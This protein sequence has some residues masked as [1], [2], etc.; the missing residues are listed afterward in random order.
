MGVVHV[1]EA[2]AEPRGADAGDPPLDIVAVCNGVGS[3]GDAVIGGC[4]I[5]GEAGGVAAEPADAVVARGHD[6]VAIPAVDAKVDAGDAVAAVP[7]VFPF[8]GTGR[9]GFSG[10][11]HQRDAFLLL[12]H[13]AETVAPVTLVAVAVHPVVALA[14]GYDQSAAVADDDPEHA[15]PTVHGGGA[16]EASAGARGEV[17]YVAGSRGQCPAPVAVVVV[18]VALLGSEAGNTAGV[19]IQERGLAAVRGGAL[20]EEPASPLLLEAF[21]CG[22]RDDGFP[23]HAY[24]E[25]AG[26]FGDAPALSLPLVA[27]LA[28]DDA[29]EL[30]I[31]IVN[32]LTAGKAF[33]DQ[34][35]AHVVAVA[36][37]HLLDEAIVSAHHGEPA[38]CLG[39]D[40]ADK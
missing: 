9:G 31:D 13:A 28:E 14:L 36:V 17:G 38:F 22:A 3:G 32:G 20:D 39:G 23:L 29:V 34:T 11:I 40:D 25:V 8:G 21:A 18:E 5:A 7:G 2:L 27:V 24:M 15:K 30:V 19:G 37:A 26:V 10:C 35:T 16:G 12:Q 6:A 4:A 1:V 33:L